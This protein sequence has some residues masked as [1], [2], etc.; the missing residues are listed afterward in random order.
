MQVTFKDAEGEQVT[1]DG[2]N[3]R[4]ALMYPRNPAT[5]PEVPDTLKYH[6]R[7]AGDYALPG[8]NIAR[9]AD[10]GTEDPIAHMRKIVLAACQLPAQVA[11]V[12]VPSINLLADALAQVKGLEAAVDSQSQILHFV[13]A[14]VKGLDPSATSLAGWEDIKPAHRH[15]LLLLSHARCVDPEATPQPSSKQV[16]MPPLPE[17]NLDGR[18]G[19]H[20]LK[21]VVPRG[22]D[23]VMVA[24]KA[25]KWSGDKV[26]ACEQYARKERSD[27]GPP[28]PQRNRTAEV[29][30]HAEL[31]RD[32]E[33]QRFPSGDG[34]DLGFEETMLTGEAQEY[35]E[36]Q[37]V[38]DAVADAIQGD[39]AP[40]GSGI[41][42]HR[43]VSPQA[44]RAR[45]ALVPESEPSRRPRGQHRLVKRLVAAAFSSVMAAAEAEEEPRD[46]PEPAKKRKRS[47]AATAECVPPC[48]LRPL[49]LLAELPV[50]VRYAAVV[51]FTVVHSIER[52][53]CIYRDQPV[54]V[55][56][57]AAW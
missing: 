6:P 39:K 53:F 31:A 4:A 56:V 25:Y 37:I 24:G 55:Q 19:H 26:V 45:A 30:A 50:R 29:R 13:A 5:A 11:P 49:A 14:L 16:A 33:M 40:D 15:H 2:P 1:V 3:V 10:A 36:E 43:S 35:V 12:R 34:A 57:C 27:K 17:P 54:L 44:E 52:R 46:D 38:M 42:E 21:V 28:R 22:A 20:V 8:A 48:A 47:S 23:A 7:I 32:L 9:C 18:I 41:L 51:P